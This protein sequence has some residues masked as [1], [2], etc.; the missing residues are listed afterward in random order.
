MDALLK[1]NLAP[2]CVRRDIAM[3]GVLHKIVLGIAPSPL[4]ELVCRSA[5]SLM[6]Y[7]FRSSVPL[8]NKQLHDCVGCN[9][10]VMLKRSFFGLVH[11]YNLLPQDLVDS[12]SVKSFQKGLT[13]LVRECCEDTLDWE[14]IFHRR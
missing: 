6:H 13:R 4:S 7:G 9:S 5:S 1:F 10:P 3:L 12:P 8:H 14:L 11:V 2:L